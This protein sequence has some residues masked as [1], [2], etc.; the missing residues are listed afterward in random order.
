MGKLA[1]SFR[2]LEVYIGAVG[3]GAELLKVP[4]VIMERLQ[5]ALLWTRCQEAS[6]ILQT[7]LPGGP[8]LGN[9]DGWSVD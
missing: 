1:Q 4:A 6:P 3:S 9:S 5:L 7:S 8:L 2:E